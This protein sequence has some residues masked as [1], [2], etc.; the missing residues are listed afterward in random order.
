MIYQNLIFDIVINIVCMYIIYIIYNMYLRINEY[1]YIIKKTS[2]YFCNM[3]CINDFLVSNGIF[4]T[5]RKFSL[6]H[7]IK[8]Y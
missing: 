8:L 3:L 2:G 4:L 1:I 5:A 7:I 6:N